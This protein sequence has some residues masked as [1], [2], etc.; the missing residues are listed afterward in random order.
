MAP[1]RA[2]MVMTKGEELPV[3]DFLETDAAVLEMDPISIHC[4]MYVCKPCGIGPDGEDPTI[5]IDLHHGQMRPIHQAW[6]VP[7]M[8]DTLKSPPPEG[9]MEMTAYLEQ[10]VLPL[11]VPCPC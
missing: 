10:G 7:L 6:V 2:D 8:E 1:K 4:V 3:A 5:D 11:C 9:A